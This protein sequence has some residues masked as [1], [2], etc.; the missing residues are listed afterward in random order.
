MAKQIAGFSMGQADILRRGMGKKKIKVIERMKKKFISG[1]IDN[2][3]T[4]E[5]A[6][7]LFETIE[8]FAGYGFNKSHKQ[9][10]G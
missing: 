6:K 5:F 4:E 1:A 3:H 7:K 10:V 2:G 9:I 8:Y